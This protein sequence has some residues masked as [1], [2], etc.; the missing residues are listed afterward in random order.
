M[1]VWKGGKGSVGCVAAAA[2]RERSNENKPVLGQR[3]SRSAHR[4]KDCQADQS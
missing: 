4:G 3:V 1:C 2:G